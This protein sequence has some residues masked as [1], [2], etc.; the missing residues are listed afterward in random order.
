MCEI[1]TLL[2]LDSPIFDKENELLE[3][4]DQDTQ[5]SITIEANINLNPNP[6]PLN[7]QGDTGLR[8]LVVNHYEQEQQEQ[9]VVDLEVL[10]RQEVAKLPPSQYFGSLDMVVHIFWNEGGLLGFFKGL[11]PTFLR[12][13]FGNAAYFGS[14]QGIVGIYMKAN[15]VK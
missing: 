1:R 14:Y 13:V 15:V 10:G 7:L 3:T 4:N 12:E 2:E 9:N 8:T 6:E 5:E 11:S